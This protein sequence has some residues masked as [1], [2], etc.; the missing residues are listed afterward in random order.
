M[1]STHRIIAAFD[2]CRSDL[3]DLVTADVDVPKFSEPWHA[4]VFGLAMA[5]AQAGHFTWGTWVDSFSA[6]ISTNRQNADENS[7]NAYYRQWL[8]AL[9]SLLQRTGAMN[10]VEMRE[11]AEHWRRSYLH[12]EHGQPIVFRRDLPSPQHVHLHHDHTA[13][14][15]SAPKPVAV[16]RLK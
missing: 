14:P 9:I 6:E 3:S 16:S 13:V 4:Q 11:T 12:T 15:L 8:T 2:P 10:D 5:M 7:E 1:D